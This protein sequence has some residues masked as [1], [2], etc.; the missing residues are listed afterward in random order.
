[1]N[2]KFYT[3][4]EIKRKLLFDYD[5]K[6]IHYLAL[7]YNYK[8]DICKM[9][10]NNMYYVDDKKYESDKLNNLVAMKKIY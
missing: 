1:M 10:L 4:D 2:I 9:Y 5:Q 7:K 3:K 6:A 8:I